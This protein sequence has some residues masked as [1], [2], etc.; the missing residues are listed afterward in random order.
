MALAQERI[1]LLHLLQTRGPSC[2]LEEFVAEVRTG[3]EKDSEAITEEEA[4]YN[5][6]VRK[7][8]LVGNILKA[9]SQA[10]I[11]TVKKRRKNVITFRVGVNSALNVPS[12]PEY[13]NGHAKKHYEDAQV[14]LTNH[15]KS[16]KQDKAQHTVCM[17]CSSYSTYC[18]HLCGRC[19][20]LEREKLEAGEDF[21]KNENLPKIFTQEL[22]QG[23]I[24]HSSICP[25]NMMKG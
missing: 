9:E 17:D 15:K 5:P 25:N 19:P 12:F 23:Q 24:L 22:A 18:D 6:K 4:A 13:V 2:Q 21:S 14:P 20:D 1:E 10:A 16:E 11:F 3:T 7:K 8:H